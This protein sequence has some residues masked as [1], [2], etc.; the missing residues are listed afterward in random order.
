MNRI[1]DQ[2]GRL[3][4]AAVRPDTDA[5]VPPFGMEARVLAA[6]REAAQ[7]PDGFWDM[8]LLVRGLMV[9]TA[10][11]AL[12]LWPAMQS[13]SGNP[14]SDYQELADSTVQVDNAP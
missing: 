11:M 4:R 7:A 5:A 9:A 2:L 14:A 3:F 8:R 12:S 13:Q 1:D 10:L 6:W